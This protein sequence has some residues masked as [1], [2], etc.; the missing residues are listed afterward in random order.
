M[1]IRDSAGRGR[2]R[3]RR[4]SQSDAEG[5]QSSAS[6]APPRSSPEA[7]YQERTER[8][9]ASVEKAAGPTPKPDSAGESRQQ[10][11]G[12]SI[13][14]NQRPPKHQRWRGHRPTT[15]HVRPTLPPHRPPAVRKNQK[16]RS[17]QALRVPRVTPLQNFKRRRKLAQTPSLTQS[18]TQIHYRRLNHL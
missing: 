12:P 1:C 14:V 6:E 2:G 8:P 10:S 3:G 11:A 15:S 18:K 5:V 13:K 17:G 16:T 9:S 4:D 7:G